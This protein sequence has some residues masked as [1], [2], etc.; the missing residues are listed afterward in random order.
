MGVLVGH[1]GFLTIDLEDLVILDV[2]DDL[3]WPQGRY[4]ESFVL[5]SLLEIWGYLDDIEGS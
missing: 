1:R 3:V 5:I 4:P 2:V